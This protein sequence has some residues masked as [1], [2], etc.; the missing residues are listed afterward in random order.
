M[1]YNT[2][3]PVVAMYCCCVKPTLNKLQIAKKKKIGHFGCQVDQFLCF[4]LTMYLHISILDSR[5]LQRKDVSDS[6][7]K[8]DLQK[9]LRGVKHVSVVVKRNM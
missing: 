8:L 6:T 7:D 5:I 2:G 4:K 9:G 3:V 1:S